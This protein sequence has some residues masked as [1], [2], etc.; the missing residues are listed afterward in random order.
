MMLA[1]LLCALVSTTPAE[2]PVPAPPQTAVL[3]GRVV[4]AATHAPVAWS[5]IALPELHKAGMADSTGRFTITRLPAGKAIVHASRV[6]YSGASATVMLS[7]NDTARVVIELTEEINSTR[8]IIVEGSHDRG[9]KPVVELSGSALRER[10]G[11]TIAETM[12]KEPGLDQRTMGAAPARPVMR[13]LG[14]DRLLLLED[15]ERTGDLS[16]TSADHAVVLDPL[17]AQSIEII[18]GPGALLYGSNTLGGVINVERDYIPT[19]ITDHIHGS[20]T[21]QLES[22]NGGYASSADLSMPI[23]AIALRTD[24]G[25]RQGFDI[26]T[27][28]GNLRNT[29]IRTANGSVGAS[30]VQSWGFLGAAGG[31]YETRYGIPGGFVGAHPNGVSIEL[32]RWH[33]EAR[34][35]VHAHIG[36]VER[37]EFHSTFSR[38]Y[39]AEYESNGSLGM[40]F[41]VLS[42]NASAIA[43]TGPLGVLH[44][45]SFGAWGEYRDYATGG[46]S[47]TPHTQE[48]SAAVFGYQRADFGALSVQAALRFDVKSVRP[49]E[50]ISSKIGAISRRDFAD[51][52][53]SAAVTYAVD[54]AL[55]LRFTLMRTF[56]APGVE[57]LYTE[58]P[59]LAAYTY[60]IGNPGIGKEN[61]IGM[62][63]SAQYT[64]DRTSMSLALFRN[65]FS[66]YIYPRN[67]GDTN[68]RV[69]LPVYQFTGEQAQM[70]GGECTGE[71]RMSDAFTAGF[72]ASYVYGQLVRT[73]TPL[74]MM[75]PLQ[76]SLRLRYSTGKFSALA[77]LH[78]AS[79]QHRT[80]DFEEPTAGYAVVSLLADYSFATEVLLHT[81]TLSV[82]NIANTE[83][84]RHL[85]RVKSI[86]PEPG[87]NIRV[88]YRLYF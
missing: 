45:G 7:D 27:P 2:H 42:Y 39:H 26:S 24:G 14:G 15:G 40:D 12:A 33:T 43:H 50:K 47:F 31:Y 29:S 54:S 8:E 62:E 38:Y 66:S 77:S 81:F 21:A 4:D 5:H 46:L 85:S 3:Q 22:V 69:L 73:T 65:Y 49:E 34:A 79:S 71:W 18:R 35:D 78:A 84:R 55:S 60:D 17:T 80:G 1:F 64:G 74:P 23:G 48:Y 67:T 44:S 25:F 75:P 13:G 86:M 10:L 61:A 20:A 83:Y 41:G 51:V 28:V 72:T 19:L 52:S 70:L 57:E 16:A 56:R 76:G 68:Y 53:G 58:G 88:L 59:H 37:I 87:R 82:D 9:D 6:G 32:N 11:G 36:P 30:Y 63:L